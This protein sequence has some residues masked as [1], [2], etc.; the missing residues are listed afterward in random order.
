MCFHRNE[1][2]DRIELLES[3]TR[4]APDYADAWGALALRVRVGVFRALTLNGVILGLRLLP[5]PSG[6][7]L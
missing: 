3:A 1:E 2:L 7:W 6:R 4:L 5:R